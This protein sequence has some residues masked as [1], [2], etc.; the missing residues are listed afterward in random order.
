MN[1]EACKQTSKR[2]V[3]EKSTRQIERAALAKICLMF[4][5]HT[6]G[7]GGLGQYSKWKFLKSE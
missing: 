3:I 1:I 6:E 5:S 4:F 7:W 2:I